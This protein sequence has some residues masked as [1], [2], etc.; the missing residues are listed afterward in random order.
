[1]KKTLFLLL[2][3]PSTCFAAG[4]TLPQVFN[5]VTAIKSQPRS[6]VFDVSGYKTKTLFVY[7]KYSSAV[8]LNLSGTVRAKCGASKFGPFTTCKQSQL[9][10]TPFVVVT[11]NGHITWQDATQWVQIQWIRAK[12]AANVWLS[13]NAN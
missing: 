1:M 13:G 2:M 4:Y 9:A 12:R 11:N 7:G 8:Y 5:N 10:S 6:A 3:I